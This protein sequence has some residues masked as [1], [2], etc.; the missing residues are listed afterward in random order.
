MPVVLVGA[1]FKWDA[2]NLWIHCTDC[3]S[4]FQTAVGVCFAAAPGRHAHSSVGRANSVRRER[5]ERP[6]YLRKA[7][8]AQYK[9]HLLFSRPGILVSDRKNKNKS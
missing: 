2:L 8:V 4:F 9:A 3:C 1:L 6:A 5:G 7:R